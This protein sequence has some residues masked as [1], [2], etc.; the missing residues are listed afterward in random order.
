MN[1]KIILLL[2]LIATA[3]SLSVVESGF[4]SLP[5]PIVP[6]FTLKLE[7]NPYDVPTVYEIDPYTGEKVVEEEGYHVENKSITFTIKN[8]AFT[9]SFDGTNYYMFYSV[10]E[11]GHFGEEWDEIY[12]YG[13]D[14]PGKL[15]LMSDSEHTVL[16]I[17]ADYP[18]GARVDFQVEAI[19]YHDSMVRVYDHMMDVIGHLEPGKSIY[20]RSGWSETHTIIIDE[21]TSTTLN[22]SDHITFIIAGALIL[23]P[24]AAGSGLLIYLSKRQQH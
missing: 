10:R 11:K 15:P 23:I 14:S 16:S 20:D 1:R 21:S 3:L 24:I 17:Q 2:V 5:K 4:S 22:L 13:D 8:Q 12:Y 9:S 6:E 18:S 19:L 7:A